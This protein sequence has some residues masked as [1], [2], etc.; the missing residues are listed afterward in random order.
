MPS[1]LRAENLS[2]GNLRHGFYT[3]GGGASSGVYASLN[4]G[5]GSRDERGKVQR[6]RALVAADLGVDESGLLTIYQIHS[7]EV[8]V[9][10]GPW[11]ADRAPKGD[12]LVSVHPGL[13][14]AILSADCTP[15]LFADEKA[16]VIGAAHAGWRGAIRGVLQATVAAMEA[17]GASRGDIAAAVG[18]CIAQPS[19]EVGPEFHQQFTAAEAGHAGYFQPSPKAGHHLFDLPG[20]VCDRLENAGVG[21]V[22][23]VGGDTYANEDQFYSYRRVT[24]RGEA[25]YGRQISAICLL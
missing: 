20:F 8:H 2:S 23:R 21:T 9:V 25:D 17:L 12:A 24:H 10:T 22:E 19:Y 5:Y 6:N 7:A 18:P 13:A 15:V 3:R 14:L 16:G 1:A 11:A 4:C